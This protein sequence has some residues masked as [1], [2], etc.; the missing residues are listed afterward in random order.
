[1]HIFNTTRFF[2]TVLLLGIV[3]NIGVHNVH[4][5]NTGARTAGGNAAVTTSSGDNNG[6]ETTPTNTTTSNNA[7]AVSLNSGTGASS[8]CALPN[9]TSDKHDFTTFGVSIPAGAVVEGITVTTEA[10]YDSGTGVNTVCSFLSWDNGTSWTTGQ[11]TPDIGTGDTTNTL[12]SAT[13]LWGRSSWTSTELNNTNFKVRIMSLVANTARDLRLDYLYVT[14][15]YS[16]P[17]AVPTQDAPANSSTGVSLTPTYT[18]TTTDPDS[19]GLGYGVAVYSNSL[20]TTKV[21]ENFQSISS[22]GWTGTNTSCTNNPTSCYTSGTQGS[23]LGQTPLSL[24]TQYWW[25]AS[26]FDP[27]GSSAYATSTSCNSF[28]TTAT[29]PPVA[30]AVSIDSGATSVT[31]IEGTTK[32]VECVG[33]VTDS[34]G[35]ADISSVTADL[36][37]TSR[38]ITSGIDDNDHYR[39]AGDSQVVPTG[40]SGNTETYTAT[41]PVQYFADAT[42]AGS[43]YAGDNWTC[44]M[45]P[46]DTATGTP[47]TD[48]VEM[49]SLFA[50]DVTS[51]IDYGVVT[52]NSNTGSVNSTTTVTNTGNRDM[53]PQISGTDMASGGDTIVAAK[54][55]YLAS[56]FTYVNNGVSLSTSPTTLNLVLP[57]RTS[58]VVSAPVY[59]GIGIPNG[60][61]DGSYT[62]TN[63]FTA[64]A[65]TTATTSP[66]FV[67]ESETVWDT[68]ANKTTSTFDVL[69]GDVLVVYTITEGYITN[70][71]AAITV[72]G[73]S[74]SWTNQ[75]TVQVDQFSWVAVW[76]A[77][78]DED[79]S[80]A[81]TLTSSGDH[82]PLFGGNVL[83]FRGSDG[84]GASSKTNDYIGS[85]SLGITTTQA[86]SAIVVVNGD[87]AAND[88]SSRE[89]MT[90][91]GAFSE[92]TYY[93]DV[94][95]YV[96]YGGYHASAGT[97]GTYNVGLNLPDFQKYS[98]I[99]VEVLGH[100]P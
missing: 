74:L 22:T 95:V 63:T 5:G 24:N 76:T 92:T 67:Q 97:I 38:L 49:A 31:L 21:Q 18:M 40:G 59:W 100:A 48:T 94:G 27:D 3:F 41:F 47:A 69:G 43:P 29:S 50:L 23:F 71:P 2:L 53:D 56:T 37:R 83:T 57:Q 85:P 89:W 82:T 7:Y 72:S 62:G 51:A 6:F 28:T 39:L 91:A 36:F 35:F 26:A 65:A 19:D 42:D 64:I 4:A 81:I 77:T 90:N 17:P 25:K 55:K 46:S 44:E 79:K 16:E 58:G 10:K 70:Q 73:G 20:C 61:N 15:Y 96:A 66:V 88:G 98:I 87:W 30:S 12:G 33:T 11:K 86:N 54:Q 84:I 80:M 13:D 52:S 68:T 8:S 99:A 32:N 14:V 93:A 1:M 75:Q 78:V 34:D 9:T 45:T 60:A